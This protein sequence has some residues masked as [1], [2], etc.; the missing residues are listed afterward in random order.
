MHFLLLVIALMLP[1]P[2]DEVEQID[3]R[4]WEQGREI[5]ALDKR[6]TAVEEDSFSIGPTEIV[7]ILTALGL[8]GKVANDFRKKPS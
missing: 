7:A 3:R 4:V 8:G 2:Q 6:L 1:A 5:A